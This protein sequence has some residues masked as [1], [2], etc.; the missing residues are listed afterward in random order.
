MQ[1]RRAKALQSQD[2][3]D[4][5][6][7]YRLVQLGHSS[8]WYVE[9]REDNKQRRCSTG[10]TGKEAAWHWLIAFAREHERPSTGPETIPEILD[11]YF[12]RYAKDLPS[13]EQAE[14][15]IRHL[16]KHFGAL[17]VSDLTIA[18]QR[19][20]MAAR[21]REHMKR[22]QRVISTETL[23][24]E[25]TRLSAAIRF[26]YD[27]ENIQVAP[28]RVKLLKRKRPR[29]KWLTRDDVAKLLIAVLRT[30]APARHLAIFIRLGIYSGP[31]P[32]QLT[33]L[34]WDRVDFDNRSIWYFDPEDEE[35]NKRAEVVEMS[36]SIH[37]MLKMAKARAE[38]LAGRRAK[39]YGEPYQPP[40][41]VIQY[42]GKRATKVHK[43]FK[44]Y[45]TDLGMP[46]V[47]PNTLRHSFATLA[48]RHANEVDMTLMDLMRAMGHSSIKT[49]MKYAKHMPG[50]HRK[51]LQAA[52]RKTPKKESR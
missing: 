28:P 25:L 22:F 31:R 15:Y 8:S 10:E 19:D 40:E 4:R 43:A 14:I 41:Y 48:A 9:W 27:E 39:R 52:R 7:K 44:R 50:Q 11:Y 5:Y 18:K 17:K 37:R 42:K 49:T 36:P 33:N 47:T 32:G 29:S 38:A 51:A 16:K 30:G 45:C 46:E 24:S 26:Y 23:N 35:T 3:I 2:Q 1:G 34:T 12:E 6:G 21:R 13:A 20:Y